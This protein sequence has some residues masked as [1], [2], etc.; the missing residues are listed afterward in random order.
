MSPGQVIVKKST[1]PK[2]LSLWRNAIN[3]SKALLLDESELDLCPNSLLKRVED[4]ESASQAMEHSYPALIVTD[5]EEDDKTKLDMVDDQ[6]VEGKK[7]VTSDDDANLKEPNDT[8]PFGFLPIDLIV[9]K[10]GQM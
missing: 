9:S 2:M 1:S 4:F 8:V 5:A 6:E 3:S 10:L 7:T